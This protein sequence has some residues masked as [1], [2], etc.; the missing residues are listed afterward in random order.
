MNL[1]NPVHIMDWW[2]A[3]IP[4]QLLVFPCCFRP[5][6]FYM[7]I[8][9]LMVN[10]DNGMWVNLVYHC[11]FSE[12]TLCAIFFGHVPQLGKFFE[13][14]MISAHHYNCY[15]R[16][17]GLTCRVCVHLCVCVCTMSHRQIC[18]ANCTSLTCLPSNINNC[19]L[20]TSSS[21]IYGFRPDVSICGFEV[22]LH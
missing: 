10:L 20:I 19:N 13:I 15:V 18:S 8:I 3:N 12:S 5:R 7:I 17:S 21:I 11:I 16:V 1:K 4:C 2:K 6:N 9:K 14:F 22:G